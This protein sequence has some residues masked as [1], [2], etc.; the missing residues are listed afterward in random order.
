MESVVKCNTKKCKSECCGIVPIE[1]VIVD[2]HRNKI[3]PKAQIIEATES[4]NIV[5][6]PESGRCGFLNSD[7][8]C[9]IYND[10]PLVCRMFGEKGNINPLLKCP[11][12]NQLT[13]TDKKIVDSKFKNLGL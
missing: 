7:H 13:E 4:T 8:G 3:N 11:H 1:K 9:K 2:L 6:I 5:F 12:L 10:R